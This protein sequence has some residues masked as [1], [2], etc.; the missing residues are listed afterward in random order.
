[1]FLILLLCLPARCKP[2]GK[3]EKDHSKKVTATTVTAR[4]PLPVITSGAGKIIVK[5]I[6]PLHFQYSLQVSSANITAPTPPGIIAP[7]S[8]TGGALPSVPRQQPPPSPPATNV[9]P[10][11]P[12]VD[13]LWQDILVTLK[14]ARSQAF[15][16]KQN[17]DTLLFAASM[18]EQCYKDRLSFYST[19]LLDESNVN[20]LKQFSINNR[21]PVAAGQ[22]PGSASDSCRRSYDDWPF[23]GLQDTEQ[24]IYALQSRLF[25]L[26]NS[27]GFAAWKATSPNSDS[28]AAVNTLVASLLT[29]TQALES[30]SDVAKNFQA[31][32]VYNYFWRA[33]IERIARSEDEINSANTE[34]QN[35]TRAIQSN[36]NDPNAK[37]AYAK[38]QA[39]Y[40]A[41]VQRSPFTF[42]INIDCSTNWYGRGRTDT[43][44]LH[45]TD[46]SAATPADQSTQIVINTCYTPAT[47]ST[48]V[49]MSFL[50]NTQYAFVSGRD[51]KNAGATISVI[52]TTTDQQV[53]PLYALQYNI[54]LRDFDN[55]LGL[56]VTV[57]AALGS[58][59]GTA[60]IEPIA[61]PS[62]SIRRRAF[63]ITPAF[64]LGRRDSLLPGFMI[65]NPQGNGLTSIPVHTSWKPGFALTFSFSVAQ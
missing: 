62:I 40:V 4:S 16:Y 15:S 63:Y 30:T 7:S 32:Q 5:Y 59:S 25:D 20:L 10:P 34:L 6:N 35:D 37:T 23:A 27:P 8:S 54:A 1:M 60:N 31:A 26:A 45:Y 51:P 56:H 46:V 41:A 22:D 55:G 12:S 3:P 24:Q 28:Y 64:Q 9:P 52:G 36:P 58:S 65:G 13:Q 61:G 2:Q 42:T 17:T 43:V 47:V 48:G 11:P 29:Q 49:G 33:R 39:A 19:F 21:T 18:E 38:S 44:S 53:T 50:R 57:G 14:N